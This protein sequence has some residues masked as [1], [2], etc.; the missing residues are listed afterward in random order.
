MKREIR[1]TIKDVAKAVGVS[2]T[3]VSRYLN[4]SGYVNE[5]TALSIQQEI[6]RL[7]YTQNKMA[8]SLKTNQTN[9]IMLVV[10]DITNSYY[11]KMYKTTQCLVADKGYM[12]VLFDTGQ[13]V[14]NELKAIKLFN[15]IGAD[16]LIFCSINYSKTVF[17]SLKKITKPIVLSNKYDEL[18]FDTL[19]SV[20]GGGVYTAAKYLIKLGHKRIAY[21]GGPEGS[22]INEMRKS[23][24][25][26]AMKED[27]IQINKD[28]FFEMDFSMDAGYKGGVYISSLKEIPTA[29]CAANDMIAMGVMLALRERGINIPEDIS[30]TGQDN[31]EFAKIS[32]PS[33]T[34]INNSGVYFAENALK[35]LFDRING[36]YTGSP[37]DI[38]YPT[39]LV[40]RDSTK[41][42]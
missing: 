24:F 27:C 29:I 28:L 1:S 31:I 40:I 22:L 4:S 39:E 21:I 38:V 9:Q 15:E 16:G 17:E 25:I 18:L 11:S 6:K 2:A 32:R 42:Q 37:R 35:M 13:K 41:K 30:L 14:D 8:K 5:K 12:A 7:N 20:S 34:T 33:L 10:P 26:K 19:H 23:G 3:T 36:I